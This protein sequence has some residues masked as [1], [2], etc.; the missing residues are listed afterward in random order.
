M[1]ESSDWVKDERHAANFRSSGGFGEA[2]QSLNR[3]GRSGVARSLAIL[4][5]GLCVLLLAPL[6][7]VARAQKPPEDLTTVSIESLM[8]MEV[9]SVSK[10]QEQFSQTAAAL[11]VI[12]QEDIRRSGATSIPELLRMVPGLDVAH[13][14]ANTW[15]ISSRGLNDRFTSKMLVLVDGRTVYSP[16]FSRVYWDVQDTLL[17][18]IERIE[19]IRGPGATLWGANAVNGV[20]N[21]ITKHAQD[22]Q[23]G[24][25]S[26]GAGNQERGFG[27][28]RY[29]GQL[30]QRGYYRFFAK[31]FDRDAFANAS[32]QPA[33]DS[34][35]ILRG[36]FRTDWTLS[37]RDSLTVQGDFYNGSVG[38]ALPNGISLSPPMTVSFNDRAHVAGGNLLSRWNHAFSPRSETTLQLYYD[39]SDREDSQVDEDTRTIDLDFDHHLAFG[40][41][42]DVVW[43]FGCRFIADQ[44][45]G[46]LSLSFHPSDRADGLFSGFVQD[47]VVLVPG[48]L[49][50]T[51]GTKLEHNAYTGFEVQPDVRLVWTPH[52]R[53]VIWGA[54]SRAVRTPSR[55]DTDIRINLAA[56]QDTGGT[57]RV[58]SLLGNPQLRSETLLAY[59]LGYRAQLSQRFALDLAAFYNSYD[60]V[61]DAKPDVPFFESNP[62]PLHLVIP[63]VFQNA[64]RGQ[65]HGVEVTPNWNVTRRWRLS[66]GYTWFGADL[67]NIAASATT[68]SPRLALDSPEQQ[69]NLRSFLNLPGNLEFDTAVYYVSNLSH[70]GVP[71]Y[72]RLD[73]R[74]GW[75]PTE[76]L[77]VG[78]VGQDLLDSRHFEFGSANQ[79]VTATEVKRSFYGKLTWRF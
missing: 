52:S 2:A 5:F 18:D 54:V 38:E 20:I 59:D 31:Y 73:T 37:A 64:L 71:S 10:K 8:Q 41:R 3:S 56:F 62:P 76:S 22:T 68:R 50:L 48:R 79:A 47:E 78:V 51:L 46:S 53:H 16:L 1:Q 23:G 33:A 19:V 28:F 42:H 43:G 70:L 27:A 57:I 29:G 61:R 49:R 21:V 77:E 17:E 30:S 63:R 14:D 4:R 75:R 6:A 74:L 36:G 44:T 45:A 72:T 24:L 60:R 26:A 65:T 32:G 40:G 25:V 35:S 11:Y 34:W 15:A 55:S 66:G 67:R 58:V 69:W 13:I 12:T 39:L 9:T 7:S